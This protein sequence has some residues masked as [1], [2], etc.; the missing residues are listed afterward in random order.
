M[1]GLPTSRQD[2]VAEALGRFATQPKDWLKPDGA[3]AEETEGM[4]HILHNG[5]RLQVH[6]MSQIAFDER[7]IYVNG[8]SKELPRHSATLLTQVCTE[9][10]LFLPPTE[11][12][13]QA[14]LLRWML[15]Q[16]T[17]EIPENP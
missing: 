4:L 3:S 8:H 10:S 17:F 1:L 11:C 15:E 9:R 16:G 2:E 7:M 12:V 5:G 13:G 6:G 14:S